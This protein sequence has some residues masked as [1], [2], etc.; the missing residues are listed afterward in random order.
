MTENKREHAKMRILF[1]HGIKLCAVLAV[2]LLVA[3]GCSSSG[4]G[5]GG[6]TPTPTPDPEDPASNLAAIA[7]VATQNSI[8][9][10]ESTT[11]TAMAYS[12]NGEGIAGETLSFTVDDPTLGFVT[13]TATTGTDGT[14]TVTFTART[15]PGTVNVTA[16]SGTV[17]SSP[18]TITILDQTSPSN[19]VLSVSSTS[20]S[21]TN[22]ATVTATVTDNAGAPVDNGTTVS[23]E[24]TNTNY[25]TITASAVT[26]AG[27]ASATFIASSNP[28]TATIRATS[29][30]ATAT[31]N[32]TVSPVAAASITFVSVSQNPIAIRST[33]VNEFAVITFDVKDVNGDPAQDIDVLFT[34]SGPD[35]GEY[36]EDNDGTPNSHTVGT[37]NGVAEVTLYSGYV[38]GP[39]T[40]SA[41]ITTAGGS[42]ITATT[43]VVSIGGGVPTDKWLSVA[44][45]R[46][47]LPGWTINNVQTEITVYLADRYGN[48][49]VLD[50]HS[51]SFETE[52]GLALDSTDAT[53]DQ[54]GTATVNVR[55][56]GS[57]Y[58]VPCE[59]VVED[60]WETT[61]ITDIGNRYDDVYGT[62]FDLGGHPRDGACSVLAYT[63]GEETFDDGSVGRPVD[64]QYNAGED[65][66][67]TADDPFRDYND[68][69]FHNVGPAAPAVDPYEPYID[70]AGDGNPSGING[71]WDSNKYIFRN[72]PF[73][74]TGEPGIYAYIE[75]QDGDGINDAS[76]AI[77]ASG[78]VDVNNDGDF[79]DKSAVVH[80]LICDAN[81]NPPCS[82]SSFSV[83][84]ENG[85][86]LVGTTEMTYPDI[87]TPGSKIE[88]T[89]TITLGDSM[90]FGATSCDIEVNWVTDEGTLTKTLPIYGVIN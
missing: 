55:T 69:G 66:T 37:T 81:Y 1:S 30:G 33:G 87:G 64:G 56:Q 48:Y 88:F 12:A 70:V 61:M 8:N 25:G 15:N 76:F 5:G 82:D 79:D 4:G 2:L 78:V 77:E 54:F 63:K 75:D 38:P 9:P 58:G 72:Y 14:A 80:F 13:S 83:T 57:T 10:S 90:T 51:V 6:T 19:V 31:I 44:A 18:R 41:S 36:I 22:T 35:G 59:D 20:V 26:N 40:I 73:L 24:V 39:V 86:K 71:V 50:G 32:I 21:V 74:V 16:A 11:L 60:A 68:D 62:P 47:N 23:F 67:D 29:G 89:A 17:S 84:V 28:G 7:L 65:F 34:M 49:N 43:P 85:L 45:E 42:T 27:T 53:A 3:A 52:M 46:R